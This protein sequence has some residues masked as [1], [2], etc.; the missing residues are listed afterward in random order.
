MKEE[1]DIFD[2]IQPSKVDTPDKSYFE[3][4]TK[5]VIQEAKPKVV[6]LHKR[7][8]VWM[9]VAAAAIIALLFVTNINPGDSMSSDPLLALNDISSE[10]ILAYV[11]ENID[12]F[13]EDEIAEIVPEEA[14]EIRDI[15]ELPE[16]AVVEE[17]AVTEASI[18]LQEVNEEEIMDYLEEEGIELLD[19]D[20]EDDEGIFI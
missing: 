11:D 7:P 13:E 17:P 15:M 6:P 4:L 1:K 18:S 2:F 19:L 5:N 10:E 20:V 9:R 8:V 16:P 14:I 12:E 3:A